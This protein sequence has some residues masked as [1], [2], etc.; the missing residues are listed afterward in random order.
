MSNHT[1]KL[2]RFRANVMHSIR[3][4]FYKQDIVEIEV[5]MMVPSP[6]MEPHLRAFRLSPHEALSVSDHYLHTSPE[7]AIKTVIGKL[8]FDVYALVRSFRDEPVSRMHYPE[9]T[10]LEWYRQN[11]D[12]H[13]LMRDVE[14][15]FQ[16]I[17]SDL[18]L[19]QQ[20]L[21]LSGSFQRITCEEAFQSYA[22]IS[23]RNATTSELLA[24]AK[25]NGLDVDPSW[26]WDTLFTM[27]YAECVEPK[28]GWPKPSFLTEFPASQAALARL[29]PTD[30]QVAERFEFYVGGSWDRPPYFGGI[31]LA[32]AFSELISADEQTK[33]FQSEQ[34]FRE[35]H[36]LPVYPLPSRMLA[37]L[38]TM[39]PTAGIA[40]GI[41]RL[42]LWLWEAQRGQ[43]VR[44]SDFLFGIN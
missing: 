29:K 7:Y 10:M 44:V 15:L 6:G 34:A 16:T 36:H 22:N 26:D 42:L 18:E 30:P 27:I 19:E 35:K 37:G 17:I 23:I 28:L 40:L 25:K 4:W 12:Y 11:A 31:E 41:E 39:R 14:S 5:P 21:D 9:F 20:T 2:V 1:K 8:D 32:N 38:S 13:Q 43:K 24:S 33:R 3:T